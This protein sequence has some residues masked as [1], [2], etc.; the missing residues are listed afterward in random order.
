VAVKVLA[1]PVVA[2]VVRGSACRAAIWTSRRSTPASSMV[3]TRV[4][5]SMCGCIRG[6][7]HA[8]YRGEVA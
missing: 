1:G 3:V 7:P 6:Q 5:R 8:R 4:C 2:H